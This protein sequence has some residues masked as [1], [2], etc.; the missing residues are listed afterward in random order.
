M[1]PEELR[2]A[3]RH[4]RAA[5]GWSSRRLSAA[6][7]IPP[8]NHTLWTGATG[9]EMTVPLKAVHPAATPALIFAESGTS[10][11]PREAMRGS[12]GEE[13][14]GAETRWLVVDPGGQR[15]GLSTLGN[16]TPTS[17]AA[18]YNQLTP[19]PQIA[20][21]GTNL[22]RPNVASI[23]AARL[24]GLQ[25]SAALWRRRPR[26]GSD[27]SNELRA[28]PTKSHPRG[29]KRTYAPLRF[30]PVF[31]LVERPV[32]DASTN[33]EVWESAAFAT[34]RSGV[35]IPYHNLKCDR[36]SQGSAGLPWKLRSLATAT[37]LIAS[38]GAI[39]HADDP[40]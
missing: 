17:L 26:K 16:T 13:G 38:A 29:R 5:H 2:R 25:T 4:C 8:N 20:Q 35:R 37:A 39:A 30:R 10:F 34:P 1:I 27:R 36:G 33:Q 24:L 9:G 23:N 3:L 19:I 31:G 40:D 7:S 14:A 15:V 22:S 32:A 21:Y 11:G 12:D 18:L 6:S 28:F